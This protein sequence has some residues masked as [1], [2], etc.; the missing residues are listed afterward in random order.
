MTSIRHVVGPL[1]VLL[2]LLF[3]GLV[4]G[5]VFSMPGQFRHMAAE[6]PE[7]GVVPWLL[8]AFSILE[9]VCLQVVIV[10]IW[11]LLGMVE[12]DTIFSREAFAWV[13]GIVRAMAVGWVLLI[14]IA[15]YVSGYLYVTPRL[16]DPGLP[17]LLFGM[18]L[19]GGV[20]VLTMA[21]MRAL[22]VQA[23]ALRT[24][25]EAVI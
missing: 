2:I 16:R 12:S 23:A 4:L 22:L 8:L 9:I 3:A 11:R 15:V 1:R 19:V 18:V 25:M 7:L 14:G 13:N 20:V 17:I 21:V 6:A 10:C 5:Q 24:E